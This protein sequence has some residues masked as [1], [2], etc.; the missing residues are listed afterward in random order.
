[1]GIGHWLL[2]N[3]GIGHWAMGIGQWAL[4]NGHWAMGIGHGV[5]H[6]AKR[7]LQV[8][9]LDGATLVRQSPIGVEPLV[10]RPLEHLRDERVQLIVV[11]RAAT[12]R[13][14]D[15]VEIAVFGEDGAWVQE[16]GTELGTVARG[17]TAKSLPKARKRPR[18]MPLA[19][20][21][22]ATRSPIGANFL[23]LSGC[24]GWRTGRAAA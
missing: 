11:G 2:D 6:G 13:R 24:Q 5:G 10:V 16:L 15:V 22:Q 17:R 18:P 23:H 9:V 4:G 12:M 8:M 1:M 7:L 21:K 14:V 19:K 3:G 20:G